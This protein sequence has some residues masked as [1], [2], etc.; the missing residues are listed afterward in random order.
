VGFNALV[1]VASRKL[2]YDQ[3]LITTNLDRFQKSE[4]IKLLA[5]M[6]SF[7]VPFISQATSSNGVEVL[8]RPESAGVPKRTLIQ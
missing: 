7:I 5:I 1:C 3:S 6:V 4:P 2:D 8:P